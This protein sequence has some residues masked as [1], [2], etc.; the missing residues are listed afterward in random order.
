MDPITLLTGG[1]TLLTFVI[2]VVDLAIKFKKSLDM[3]CKL[4]PVHNPA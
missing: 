3:V 4:N 1:I 2:D